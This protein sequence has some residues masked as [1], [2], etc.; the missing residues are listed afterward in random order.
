MVKNGDDVDSLPIRE[1]Y[2]LVRGRI[3]SGMTKVCLVHGSFFET[4]KAEELIQKAFSQVIEERFAELD[5]EIAQELEPVLKWLLPLFSKR[6]SFSKVR[7][8]ES[9]SVSLRF[10]IMTE[11]NVEA[12]LLS[13]EKYPL[14]RD[15]TLNLV[16]PSHTTQQADYGQFLQAAFSP[17]EFEGLHQFTIRYILNGD[18]YVFQST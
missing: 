11:V 6:E 13:S 2:Y 7:Q 12:N 18:F 4:I 17:S 1:V 9:A 5:P 3:Q 16:V 8:V 10:R 15:N 14:I